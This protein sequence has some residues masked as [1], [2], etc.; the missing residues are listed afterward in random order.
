MDIENLNNEIRKIE[1]SIESVK[2]ELAIFE[3]QQRLD[4]EKKNSDDDY[5]KRVAAQRLRVV[6]SLFAKGMSSWEVAEHIKDTFGSVWDAYYFVTGERRQEK[7]RK[8]YARYYLIRALSE[9]GFS[10]AK[11][12]K[13]AGY[14]PQRCGQILKA[15]FF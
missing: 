14:S 10:N 7:A 12:S 5:R 2:A 6:Y 15:G 11:I 8:R 13:I 4:E 1:D 9:A 3:N